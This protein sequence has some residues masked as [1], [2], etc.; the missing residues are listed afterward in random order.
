MKENRKTKGL[1]IFGFKLGSIVIGTFMTSPVWLNAVGS[2]DG[3]APSLNTGSGEDNGTE[4]SE[5]YTKLTEEVNNDA[6]DS[7]TTLLKGIHSLL[8]IFESD[9]VNGLKDFVVQLGV[10]PSIREFTLTDLPLEDNYTFELNRNFNSAKL[11]EL[12]EDGIIPTLKET[13]AHFAGIPV[14]SVIILEPEFTGA[15]ETI[16][17]DYADILVL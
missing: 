6:N 8:Q 17:V 12:L 4:F 1:G 13:E 5:F 7:R 16:T 9:E 2:T 15:E 10:E 11:A 3:D 14:T